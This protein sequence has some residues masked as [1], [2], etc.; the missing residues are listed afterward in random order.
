M[1]EDPES[2]NIKSYEVN[3]HLVYAGCSFDELLMKKG[4]KVCKEKRLFMV[5]HP[6]EEWEKYHIRN[7]KA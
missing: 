1:W 3:D 7:L 6:K 5:L 2:A 4:K